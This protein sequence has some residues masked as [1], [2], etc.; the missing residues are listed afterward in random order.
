MSVLTYIEGWAGGEENR[1]GVGSSGG[2]G[3]TFLEAPGDQ[4]GVWAHN[5][6]TETHA[7]GQPNLLDLES[8]A[9]GVLASGEAMILNA[10]LLAAVV[11]PVANARNSRAYPRVTTSSS[12]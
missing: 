11:S 12:A 8:P 9:L 3:D 5:A 4:Y 10:V 6:S 2:L 7:L 1:D